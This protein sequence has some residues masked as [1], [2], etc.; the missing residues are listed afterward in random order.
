[1]IE[2]HSDHRSSILVVSMSSIT[3]LPLRPSVAM[4]AEP[5]VKENEKMGPRLRHWRFNRGIST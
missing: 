5:A 2:R 4:P 3:S 1:M